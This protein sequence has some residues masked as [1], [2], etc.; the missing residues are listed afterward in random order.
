MSISACLKPIALA[1]GLLALSV[2][3]GATTD[4]ATVKALNKAMAAKSRPEKDTARDAN[5]LPVETLSFFGFNRGMT[6]VELIPGGGWYTRLLAPTLR[7]KGKL[8]VAYGTGYLEKQGVLKQK[9]FDKVSLIAP[10]SKVYRPENAPRYV[11]ENADLGIKDADMVL[12]FRNYHNFG[13]EGRKAMNDAAF[14]ALKSGGIYGVV[15]HTRRHMEPNSDANRRR[16]DPVLAIKEIEAAGFEFVD[17]SP[18][19]YRPKDDTTLEVG[20]AS[21]TGHTDRWT[22]KFRKP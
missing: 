7:D 22:L 2:T 19:H 14:E 10:E 17:Y 4:N 9:G 11:L 6:V 21:V 18:L 5:R 15:D 16:I 13:A 3:A 20:D 8:Y 1:A 12:T